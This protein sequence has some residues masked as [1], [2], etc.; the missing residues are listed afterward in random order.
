[1]IPSTHKHLSTPAS[2]LI[3]LCTL[4]LF[5]LSASIVFARTWYIKP[6]GSGDA[7]TIQA[8]VD[9]AWV[10]D[11]II[12]SSGDYSNTQQVMIDGINK[13]VNIH[14]YKDIRML[15]ETLEAEVNIDGTFSDIGVYIENTGVNSELT[16]FNISTEY[17][18]YGCIASSNNTSLQPVFKI[19]IQCNSSAITIK[20]NC[21]NDNGIAIQLE[22]SPVTIVENE[23]VRSFYGIK[24]IDIS[25]ASILDNVISNCATLIDCYNSSPEII[26][27]EI[28]IG[29]DAIACRVGSHAYI[30]HNNIHMI[31]VN[32]VAILNSAPVIEENIFSYN[33]IGV[34][35]QDSCNGL[36]ISKNLFN[37]HKSSVFSFIAVH[38]ALITH[39]TIDS[40]GGWAFLLQGSNPI[41][42]NNIITRSPVG[43]RCLG[44][45]SPSL[46]CNNF[47][48]VSIRY[49]GECEDLTGTN[50]N[51][52]I[53]PEFCG[54]DDSGN[55]YLQ[56]DSPCA[57]G[58]HPFG[59]SC[60]QIGCF[61]VNCGVVDTKSWTWGDIKRIYR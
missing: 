7:P 31:D 52:S 5:F 36:I 56:S 2:H 4:L 10:G 53:D 16:G 58:N 27:N 46:E 26:A 8:G 54:I 61:S 47:Y 43:L 19:G 40:I 34:S 14:I 24:C 18:P 48:A 60:G 17:H 38:D 28:F 37:Y 29:C 11:T 13:I 57:P 9:S 35:A 25:D 39:N 49:D 50:G 12:V 55:Y 30:L 1:M 41:I 59:Y 22:Q 33:E 42:N 3:F 21:I 51:I 15:T 45:S 32:G 6:D 44:G 23:I 20:G